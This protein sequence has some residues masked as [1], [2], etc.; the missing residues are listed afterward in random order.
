MKLYLVRHGKTDAAENGNRQTPD[1]PLG[2]EG[3]NELS[4]LVK[5]FEG[6]EIDAIVSSPWTRAK[7]T[8]E[9]IAAKL[10]L[11]IHFTD[12]VRERTHDN[13]L[14]GAPIDSRIN[15]EYMK[16]IEE[17]FLNF[18]WKYLNG[19]S[20][21]DVVQRAK[22]ARDFLLKEY[23][24]K[25][26]VLVSHGIFFRCFLALCLLGDNF[27]KEDF[28]KLFHSFSIPTASVTLLEYHS[29]YSIWEIKYLGKKN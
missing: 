19:E 10:D 17:N 24:E 8:A 15:L 4:F 29:N 18:D 26:V 9:A 22:K 11:P 25:T 21:P 23:K 14:Q 1:T 3:K 16:E 5:E 27:D 12:L 28:M 7:E 6:K 20:L 2:E 13:R